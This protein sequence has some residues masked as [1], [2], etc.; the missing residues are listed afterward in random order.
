M[1][2]KGYQILGKYS[3]S[4]YLVHFP[5]ITL[6]LYQP[7][8]GMILKPETL[9]QA[10]VI[11]SAIIAASLAMFHLVET[12]FRHG[13]LKK[14]WAISY[15]AFVLIGLSLLPVMTWQSRQG[16]SATELK[17]FDAWHDRSE[18]R[19]GK[20]KRITQIRGKSCALTDK[21]QTAEKT[22]LLVGN[23]HADAIKETLKSL[24]ISRDANLNMMKSN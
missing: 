7:Y 8:S 10:V 11:I 3:Y 12:P 18:Y 23:S 6:I 1:L 9:P 4:I 16:Y 2:G 5:I 14:R 21:M 15:I 17:V 24:A 20:L 13:I 19:C 22:Y